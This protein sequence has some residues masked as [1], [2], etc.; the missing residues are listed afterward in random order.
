[1]LTHVPR[2]SSVNN[3]TVCTFF[4][5]EYSSLTQDI[6]LFKI[7]ENNISS[8]WTW[9]C[10]IKCDIESDIFS[11][12]EMVYLGLYKDLKSGWV[13]SDSDLVIFDIVSVYPRT[14]QGI[15]VRMT[16]GRLLVRINND[17]VLTTNITRST[18]SQDLAVSLSVV[19][20][21]RFI[22]E[23]F[24]FEQTKTDSQS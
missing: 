16:D 18:S 1:M 2:T 8:T 4:K 9:H 10:D 14:W 21:E 11:L 3:L 12:Q 5:T 22:A 24:E 6:S 23:R 15:C 17:S 19:L 7:Q 20:A 13:E